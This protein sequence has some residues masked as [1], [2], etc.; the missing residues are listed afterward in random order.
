M[1]KNYNF[2]CIMIAFITATL[3]ITSCRKDKGIIETKPELVP[4]I[5]GTKGI[6]V[7]SEGSMDAENSKISYY[8]IEKGTIIADYYFQVNGT[9]LGETAND[10]KIYGGKMYCV[11]SGKQGK[12][13]SFVDIMNVNTGKTIKRIPFN[14]ATD[15]YMPRY[16][17]F[18]K[19]K[20]YV[21]R[22]DGKISRVDTAS[23]NIDGELQLKNGNDNAEALE[24]LAVANGKL[25]VA[26]SAYSSYP[27]D[28]E[29]KVVVIDLATF[30]KTKDITVNHNPVRIAAT[31]NG[32]LY[33]ISWGDYNT[34]IP[35]LQRINSITDAVVQTEDYDLGAITI[36]KNQAWVTK[37]LYSSIPNV[38]PSIKALNILTGKIGSDLI[39]DG[40]AVGSPYGITI[41]PFDNSVVVAQS[42]GKVN[43][44]GSDG[45]KKY[46]FDT[47]NYFP[48][49]AA[50]VYNYKYVQK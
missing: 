47:S 40:T 23:L 33:V 13:K 32:D 30:T 43:V 29:N 34:I 42:E 8:D 50:F 41:N 26:G 2:K 14:S 9:N 27:N 15:G 44:F 16:I 22:Y 25:Y 6:Y 7:L 12:T 36:S 4:E 35:A 24:G 1:N 20:A 48:Q 39:S 21:S 46:G 28:L 11:V 17:A 49:H 10:L 38:N 31:E 18:Y 3:L 5:T 19:D 37:D 45:K